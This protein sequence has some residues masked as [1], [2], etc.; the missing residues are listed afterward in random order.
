MNRKIVAGGI[1]ALAVAG[2]GAA[3]AATQLDSPAERSAAIVNDAAGQLGV[4]PSQL[5]DALKKAEKN[6]IDAEVAAGQI[7]Q[8]QGDAMKAA[9]DSGKAPLVNVGPGGFDDHGPGGFGHGFGGGGP[10]DGLDAAATYLG[11]TGDQLRTDLQN[12][13]S[14]ADVAKAQGKT[15]DGLVAA[16]AADAKKNIDAAVTAGK[17]TQSQ[18]DSI[19]SQLTQ[20]LTDRVNGTFPARP[21]FGG[22]YGFRGGPGFHGWRPGDDGSGPGGQ[23]SGGGTG[24]FGGTSTA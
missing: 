21:D 22:G 13:Q 4:Q 2:G 23:Q 16:M 6:Q 17:L 8:E 3:I 9:I 24:T 7:T 5:S 20:R 18:A 14:L 10:F 11:V 1:A 12:G 15:A 19:E